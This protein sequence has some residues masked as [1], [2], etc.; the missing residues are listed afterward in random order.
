MCAPGLTSCPPAAA[1][2]S[3]ASGSRR[4]ALRG[5]HAQPRRPAIVARKCGPSGDAAAHAARRGEATPH[6]RPRR[7]R[8]RVLL[9]LVVG[10]LREVAVGGPLYANLH[11]HAQLR[12]TLTLLRTNLAEIRTLTTTAI[13]T[14]DPDQL[15]ILAK[16]RATFSSRC[17]TSSSE[18]CRDPGPG[19]RHGPRRRQDRRGD[20]ATTAAATFEVM[21]R[22]DARAGRGARAASIASGGSPTKW[23][24]PSTPSPSGTRCRGGEPRARDTPS[25]DHRACWSRARQRGRGADARDRRFHHEAPSSARGG[26]QAGVWGRVHGEGGGRRQDEIGDLARA[27]NAMIDELSRREGALEAAREAAEAANRAKS[28]FLA[29]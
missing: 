15:R 2:H 25:L 22:G 7:G 21:L 28:E 5:V 14:S 8:L 4:A 18:C 27:F 1:G 19:C 13:Y 17:T 12:Q 24:T 16:S 26:V 23:T 10:Q 6:H 29:T 9:G 20:F 3:S 11:R